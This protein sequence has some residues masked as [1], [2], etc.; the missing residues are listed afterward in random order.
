[1]ARGGDVL[2]PGRADRFVQFVDARDVADW[3]VRQLE[4]RVGGAYNVNEKP[5]ALTF[6]H[7]LAAM[8]AASRSNAACTWVSDAF[9]QQE[10]VQEWSELPL[11]VAESTPHITGFMSASVDRALGQG[12]TFRALEQTIQDTLAWRAT[13]NEPL[14]TGLSPARER[15]VL[16]KYAL[17]KSW[18]S[19]SGSLG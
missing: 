7:L 4:Q 2:A 9:L 17:L 8:G 14:K 12:L 5:F 19:G 10:Q 3:V 11:Y 15:E 16:A 18:P 1:M 6:A 13:L